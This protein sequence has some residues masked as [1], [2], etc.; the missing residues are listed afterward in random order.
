MKELD[1]LLARYLDTRYAGAPEAEQQ[2]FE[3]LLDNE[4]P[5]LWSWL[6]EAEPVSDGNCDE[7]VRFLR[8]YR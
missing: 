3:G 1:L 5:V 8:G 4:D 7:L 6:I 2:A